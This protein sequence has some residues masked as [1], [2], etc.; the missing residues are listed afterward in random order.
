MDNTLPSIGRRVRYIG[1][2]DGER[3]MGEF[4]EP[5]KVRFG[6]GATAP[7]AWMCG[8]CTGLV[9]EHHT[10]YAEHACPNHGEAPECI[11]GDEDDGRVE[12]MP[13][14]AVVAWHTDHE[15]KT[16]QRCISVEDEDREWEHI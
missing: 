5:S 4:L 13:P 16:I 11:C 10:G 12:A 8:G 2:P 7:T 3:A 14:W 9:T 6:F 15:G 1:R